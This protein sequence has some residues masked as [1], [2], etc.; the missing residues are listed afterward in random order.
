M[1]GTAV[2]L[3]LNAFSSLRETAA[4]KNMEEFIAQR[5]K[6][7]STTEAALTCGLRN[8]SA[9]PAVRSH[10]GRKKISIPDLSD[11]GSVRE[12][13]EEKFCTLRRDDALERAIGVNLLVSKAVCV[14]AKARTK[15]NAPGFKS[16]SVIALTSMRGH[17]QLQST[18]NNQPSTL[19]YQLWLV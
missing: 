16:G 7:R 2:I 15:G 13:S 6:G 1:I 3:T 9:R 19:S 5:R 18:V 4:V 12:I 17:L 14:E 10:Q 11:F 8:A